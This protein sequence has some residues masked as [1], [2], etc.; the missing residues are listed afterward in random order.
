MAYVLKRVD[1]ESPEVN[2]YAGTTKIGSSDKCDLVV[3]SDYVLPVHGEFYHQIPEYRLVASHSAFIE[4]NDQEVLKWP[5]VLADGDVITIGDVKFRFYIVQ[6]VIK[7][8]RRAAFS[9]YLATGFL[10]VLVVFELFVMILL[11]FKLKESRN[12]QL[13][14]T[15]EFTMRQIDDLR[16]ATMNLNVVGGNQNIGRLK[17][18]LLTCETNIANYLRDYGAKMN[19]DQ[20]F[21]IRKK[22]YFI[23]LIVQRWPELCRNLTQGVTLN[24]TAY[25]HYLADSLEMETPTDRK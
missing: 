8:S 22:L 5:A 4:I 16:N 13:A 3:K 1:D 7:R 24:P 6:T 12:W 18:L 23:N 10:T 20:A 15:R 19:L 2:I 17:V 9:S 21:A 14:S 11:P 25:M